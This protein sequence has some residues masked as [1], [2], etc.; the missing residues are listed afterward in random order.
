MQ[1]KSVS[2]IKHPQS[3]VTNALQ[4]Q[5]VDLAPQLEGVESI[6]Q[7][8]RQDVHGE[9]LKLEHLW[10]AKTPTLSVLSNAV[11]GK[12]LTWVE[13]VAWTASNTR[14]DWEITVHEPAAFVQCRGSTEV[15][16]AM[17]G[18]GTRLTFSGTVSLAR[19]TNLPAWLPSMA[20]GS[21]ESVLGGVFTGHFQKL[22]GVL[23]QFLN[24]SVNE[25]AS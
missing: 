17:A 23:E 20:I 21:L 2:V 3:L 10:C 11:V 16:P 13:A 25:S 12:T 8:H 22:S 24:Q 19:S 4:N 1:F 15:A 14:C 7:L 9:G 6:A 5:L 18:R